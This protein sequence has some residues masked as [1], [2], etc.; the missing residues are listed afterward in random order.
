MDESKGKFVI[1]TRDGVADPDQDAAVSELGR[2]LDKDGAKLLIYLHGGLVSEDDGVDTANRLMG[3]GEKS[4]NLDEEW[5][6]LYVVWRTGAL[7]TVK[8]NWKDL[9]LNDRLYQA[10][11][12]KLISFTSRKLGIQTVG[13]SRSAYEILALDEAEIH[14]RITGRSDRQAP[15]SDLDERLVPAKPTGA[16]ASL[17]N[18]QSDAAL[19]MGFEEELLADDRF[20][21][22]AAD[23]EG[24]VN[25]GILGRAALPPNDRIRGLASY[26][27]LSEEI[28]Q[29]MA[30]SATD[31][32]ARG[33]SPVFTFLLKHAGR[34]A[35]RCF[36]RF[37][38]DRDHG[39]HATVVE[40]LCRELYGDLIGS[41]L[42]G[43]MVKDAADHFGENRFG[44]ILLD[45]IN[46]DKQVPPKIVVVAHSAGS[47]WASR[48]LLAMH[49]AGMNSRI[50]L[51]LL[52]PA[53][54]HSLFVE[55][56]KKAGSLIERC[57][58]YAMSDA[59][60]RRDAVLGHDWGFI[61]PSSLLYLVSGL[62]EEND[63]D[64][65][66]DAP[67]V[68]MQRFLGAPWMNPQE[69][70]DTQVLS[71]F[72]KG[73]GKDI[74]LSPTTDCSADCHGCFDNDPLTLKSARA[75]F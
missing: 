34:I 22:A 4:W 63:H 43:M 1:L 32:G 21:R 53:A 13:G 58:M 70:A 40:E 15:F 24:I 28:R 47:I 3:A 35:L 50:K 54:R 42:W 66:P 18:E 57:R 68:G 44:S 45:L 9:A 36:R 2:R 41:A 33:V 14:R 71:D 65:Y 17:P 61:Y 31:T 26:Q 52:A 46:T 29:E 5:T 74:V 38:S 10:I 72:F 37:R 25:E 73:S 59:L 27:R 55:T 6:Q 20:A 23:I 51:F 7:E 62:C 64:A 39:V 67:I 19:A 69:L 56:I 8:A 49:A 30:P 11:L 75:L 48:M 12:E 60:E 16:R